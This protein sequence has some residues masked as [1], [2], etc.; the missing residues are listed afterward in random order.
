MSAYV[1]CVIAL[2]LSSILLTEA[3]TLGRRGVA[4]R[5]RDSSYRAYNR[6]VQ[7]HHDMGHPS[8]NL[9]YSTP[10]A[11]MDCP[12][13]ARQ[14]TAGALQ[15]AMSPEEFRTVMIEL[16]KIKLLKKLNLKQPPVINGTMALPEPLLPNLHNQMYNDDYQTY[17]NK[18]THP[19]KQHHM[20]K[21]DEPIMEKIAIIGEEGEL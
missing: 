9:A 20:D 3:G 19:R 21:Q 12:G 5:D 6:A 17:N 15:N 10:R 18:Y 2:A 4:S 14:V 11:G 7:R 13:C 8:T 16:V 1:R